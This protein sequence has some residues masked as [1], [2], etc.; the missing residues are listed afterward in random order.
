MLTLLRRVMSLPDPQP[1]TPRVLGMDDFATWHGQSYA[2][3]ITDGK[4]HRP[5]D[6]LSGHE[7]GPLAAWLTAH[8]RVEIICQ[9]R[10]GAPPR[11]P[12]R[13]PWRMGAAG[14]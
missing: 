10:A 8:P 4:R 11:G 9:G 5:T 12:A 14:L 6:V 3:A 7:A 2:T 1:S 13:C